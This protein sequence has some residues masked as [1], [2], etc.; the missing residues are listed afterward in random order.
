MSRQILRH[1]AGDVQCVAITHDGRF[2][3]A[4]S[5]SDALIWNENDAQPSARFDGHWA[6]IT[7]LCFSPDGN[8]LFTAAKD[9]TVKV[10]DTANFE[11]PMTAAAEIDQQPERSISELLT[12]TD[13][14]GFV[15]SVRF[16]PDERM[17]FVL[18]TGLDGQAIVWPC[19]M[20]PEPEPDRTVHSLPLPSLH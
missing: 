6:D 7:A 15:T 16:S 12:L 17:P 20:E 8:R 1:L 11:R 2:I 3:A 14:R 5:N 9:F 13:H 4:G 19:K 10:W 18:T